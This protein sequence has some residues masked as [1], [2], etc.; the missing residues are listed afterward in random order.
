MPQAPPQVEDMTCGHIA[1]RQISILMR[2]T[3]RKWGTV[4]LIHFPP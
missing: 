2:P 1:S 4:L 3:L